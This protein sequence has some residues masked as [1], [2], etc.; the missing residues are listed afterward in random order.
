MKIEEKKEKYLQA[1]RIMDM[2]NDSANLCKIKN[3]GVCVTCS[4]RRIK[5]FNR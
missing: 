5:D 2:F 4:K 1:C 3:Y